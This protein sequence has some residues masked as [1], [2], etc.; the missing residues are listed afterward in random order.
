MAKA[1]I[2]ITGDQPDP[3]IF[4]FEDELIVGRSVRADVQIEGDL[5]SRQH[6]KFSKKESGWFFE[7]L[8]SRNGSLLNGEK[9]GQAHI[10]TGDVVMIGYGKIDF[11]SL[12]GSA[13]GS[14]V[15]VALADSAI[16]LS[17]AMVA[18]IPDDDDDASGATVALSYQALISINQRLATISRISRQLAVVLDRDELL[19]SVLDTLFEL[20]EQIDRSAIVL[21]ND[22]GMFQVVA[23]R[24]QGT[25][26]TMSAMRI[27]TSLISFV[28]RERKAVLSA[29]TSIDDRFS[30]GESI[31]GASGRSIMCAPL[32]VVDEFL[33]VIYLDTES[34]QRPFRHN[35]LNLLQGIAG[36]MA[37]FLKN[38]ELI[39]E[40]ETETAMRTSLS[41]YLS[42][43]VVRE[44]GEGSLS[45]NLGGSQVHG[46]IM[47]SD[48]VGFTAMSEKMSPGEVVERLNRYFT[49]MLEAVFG[50]EGTVDK[51]G[52]DAILAVW[53]AP[54]P[55]DDHALLAV[56]AGL[57]MQCRLFELNVALEENDE[58]TIRMA[59]GLNSGKFVAGNIG[60][61]ERIEWTVIGDTVNLAQ[62]VESSGWAET[63]LC[64]DS[65]WAEFKGT[66]GAYEFEPINVK[67]KTVPVT[68]YSIRTVKGPRG[69][70][71]ALPV[72]V[73]WKGNEAAGIISKVHTKGKMKIALRVAGD[74]EPETD[75]EIVSR[76]PEHPTEL[77]LTGSVS[78]SSPLLLAK[79][80]RMIEVDVMFADDEM[81]RLF[82]AEGAV[83]AEL[84]LSQIDR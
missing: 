40:I 83:P 65:T 23:T 15:D 53:G 79:T 66:A 1:R 61:E 67:N 17:T 82:R 29:D 49:S 50:W 13:P 63:M 56:I 30:G 47:F 68:I 9:I 42:P 41:R 11:E 3:R 18:D 60:G 74:P 52:G 75:V 7:D 62:R 26:N 28:Q 20:F 36:P 57:E 35:D 6:A 38:A 46:T 81:M 73:R 24:Q 44:I 69:V 39:S 14:D 19:G 84:Q 33:G 21:R 54:V 76:T 37:I 12:D 70:T 32:Q 22:V 16:D 8:G 51:F 48:I 55:N 71:A 59:V 31:V 64:S 34:L 4:E 58:T 78:S 72:K 5:V 77:R 80:G 10:K 25:S 27:S 43:D 2:T 45:A